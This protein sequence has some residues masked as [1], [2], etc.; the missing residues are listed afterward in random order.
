MTFILG[1][2]FWLLATPGNFLV[3]VLLVGVLWFVLSRRRRGF[4]LVV[5]AV[6]V[7]TVIAVFPVGEWLSLPLENRFSVPLPLPEKIDGIVLLGGPVEDLITGA[8]AQIAL[9]DAVARLTDAE[10]LARRFAL[11]RVVVTGGDRYAFAT[12]FPEGA[13]MRDFL[14]ARGVEPERIIAET[15]ARTTYEN[16]VYSLEEAKPKPGE[17]WLLVTS[18]L[19]MPRAVGCFR[20]VG[21]TVLPYPVDYRTTGA[22]SV[23]PVLSFE[24]ELELVTAA[25]KEWIGL[26]AYRVLDHTDALFPAPA[27]P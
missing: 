27:A 19:H 24:H 11:A 1:K 8:R 5:A 3:L 4:A 2:I 17:T 20:K 12:G 14:V 18:A 25:T 6:A 22:F 16:A 26:V 10:V 23:R 7:M 21:W 15:R 13:I 9:N